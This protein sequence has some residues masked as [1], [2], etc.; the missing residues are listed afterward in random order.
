MQVSSDDP[1]GIFEVFPAEHVP[2]IV[3]RQPTE[4]EQAPANSQENNIIQDLF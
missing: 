2:A 1:N 3:Q 4:Q